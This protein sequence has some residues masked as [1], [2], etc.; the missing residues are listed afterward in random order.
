M[1][2]LNIDIPDF[3]FIKGSNTKSSGAANRTL[4]AKTRIM[5]SRI[6]NITIKNLTFFEIFLVLA[7]AN[8]D[9]AINNITKI[10]IPK[11]TKLIY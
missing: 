5:L 11:K 7:F 1:S 2:A 3:N 4:P 8:H 10:I 6:E 9:K